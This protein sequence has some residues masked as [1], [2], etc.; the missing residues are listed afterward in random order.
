MRLLV[1]LKGTKTLETLSAELLRICVSFSQGSKSW[2]T[3]TCARVGRDSVRKGAGCSQYRYPA[4]TTKCVSMALQ[5]DSSFILPA[6]KTTVL[7]LYAVV[8]KTGILICE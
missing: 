8:E 3:A 4:P 2:P 1:F 6:S 5:P 7:G